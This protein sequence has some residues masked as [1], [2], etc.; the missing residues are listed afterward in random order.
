MSTDEITVLREQFRAQARTHHLDPAVV[1]AA[2][3]YVGTG[4]RRRA[5]LIAMAACLLGVLALVAGYLVTRPAPDHRSAPG[6]ASCT[7]PV[8]LLPTWA[9]DGFSPDAYRSPFVLADGGKIVAIP[10]GTLHAPPWKTQN[11]KILWV[12]KVG[13][14]GP[15][16]IRATLGARLVTRT[17]ADVG[18]SYV[19][20]PAPG[21]WTFELSWNGER[22]TLR[23]PYR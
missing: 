18:P 5:P 6:A 9:R 15:L 4:R 17:L 10:F 13:G 20:M 21:C 11:N 16:H 2:L 3:P 8:G 23:L 7:V 1:D 19:N 14:T 22:D 12:T